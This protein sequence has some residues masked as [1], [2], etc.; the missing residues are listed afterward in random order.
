[1]AS[2]VRY[3]AWVSIKIQEKKGRTERVWMYPTACSMMGMVRFKVCL[4]LNLLHQ[5]DT[6]VRVPMPS[7]L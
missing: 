6:G 5:V 3:R 1:M 2:I 7:D 4:R